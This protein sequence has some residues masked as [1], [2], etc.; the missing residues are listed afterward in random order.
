[1]SVCCRERSFTIAPKSL[2]DGRALFSAAL[3][4]SF[5]LRKSACGVGAY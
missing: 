3:G 2:R 4:E 1:M 5:S